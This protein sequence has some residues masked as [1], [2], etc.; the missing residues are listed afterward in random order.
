MNVINDTEAA[1]T[2]FPIGRE[3]NWHTEPWK[4]ADRGDFCQCEGED[5]WEN[6]CVCDLPKQTYTDLGID[7]VYSTPSMW[8]LL[9]APGPRLANLLPKYP[10][11]STGFKA[12]QEADR[13]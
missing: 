3:R 9:S 10:W 8:E 2:V 6:V 4:I 7:R 5:W 1:F 11:K 12:V 13:G